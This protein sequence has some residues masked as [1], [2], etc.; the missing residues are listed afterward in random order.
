[1]TEQHYSR[2]QRIDLKAK[3]MALWVKALLAAYEKER[4]KFRDLPPGRKRTY[5]SPSLIR[6]DRLRPATKRAW[7]GARA[8]NDNRDGSFSTDLAGMRQILMSRSA[9]KRRTGGRARR[10]NHHQWLLTTVIPLG[11]PLASL[12][13]QLI[14][15]SVPLPR[16]YHKAQASA[17]RLSSGYRRSAQW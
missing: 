3:G 6:R 7:G 15:I 5:L 1:V 9:C 17:A 12:R 8:G 11:M 2:S 4:R 10:R 13:S 14:N 16:V